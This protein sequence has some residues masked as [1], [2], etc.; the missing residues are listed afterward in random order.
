MPRILGMA[1]GLEPSLADVRRRPR[2]SGVRSI[3]FQGTKG[4]NG[5]TFT[6][7]ALSG[8]HQLLW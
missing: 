1:R 3:P 8:A 4:K 2:V 5:T 6:G 7:K